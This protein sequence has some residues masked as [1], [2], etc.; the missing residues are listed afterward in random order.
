GRSKD[1]KSVSVPSPTP[2]AD[3]AAIKYGLGYFY[4]IKERNENQFVSMGE[5]AGANAD[6]GV[7]A[8][9]AQYEKGKFSIGAIEYY[10]PDVINIAYAQTGYQIPLGA[11]LRLKLAAQYTDGGSVGDNLLQGHS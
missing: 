11:D 1:E 5:D 9:G 6:R 3:V 8:A 2:A 4:K 7:W 10:C